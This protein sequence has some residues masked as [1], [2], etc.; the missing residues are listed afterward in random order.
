MFFKLSCPESMCVGDAVVLFGCTPFFVCACSVSVCGWVVFGFFL[1]NV[2]LSICFRFSV[3]HMVL[4]A[5]FVYSKFFI[6]FC[7]FV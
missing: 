1:V 4:V 6:L 2:C 3:G 7:L 5:G